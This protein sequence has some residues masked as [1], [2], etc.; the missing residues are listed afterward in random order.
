MSNSGHTLT[1]ILRRPR[2]QARGRLEGWKQTRCVRP[3]FETPA[4]GRLLRMTAERVAPL[5]LS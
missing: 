3:S 5:V 1:V 4:F 2:A